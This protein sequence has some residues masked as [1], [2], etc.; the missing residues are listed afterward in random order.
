MHSHSSHCHL[1]T[2]CFNTRRQH[3][4]QVL[5]PRAVLTVV[6]YRSHT[7]CHQF[8]PLMIHQLLAVVRQPHQLTVAAVKEIRFSLGRGS[9]LVHRA[10]NHRRATNV[11]QV[12]HWSAS[13]HRCG[14][15]PF[16]Q[17]P[18]LQP[19]RS[20]LAAACLAALNCPGV[21]TRNIQN[22]ARQYRTPR[23]WTRRP[24]VL[25]LL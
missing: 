12:M 14:T 10:G 17:L 1:P 20:V 7:A 21:V 2:R 22:A 5:A 25:V 9:A 13:I 11:S 16:C 24:R 23:D 15:A 19:S 4:H 6:L 8:Q 18:D 3:E